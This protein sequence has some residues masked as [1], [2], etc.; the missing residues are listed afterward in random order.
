VSGKSSKNI[1]KIIL[2]IFL[3]LIAFD[4]TVV[5]LLFVPAVQT[6]AVSKVTQALSK[7]WESEISIQKVRIS[8]TLKIKVQ[9]VTIKDHHDNDMI[10]AATVKGRLRGLSIKPLELRFGKLFLDKGD[11]TLRTYAH[12]KDIN[13]SLW[14]IRISKKAKEQGTFLLTAQ[15]LTLKDT[16][17]VLINDN[18]RVVFD[19]RNHPDID[20]AY[21]EFR[22]INALVKDFKVDAKQI[23]TIS[24][25]F[26]DLALNQYSGF[27][28]LRCNGDFSICDTALNFQKCHI[29]TPSSNLDFDLGFSYRDWTTLGEFV[30]SVVIT[31]NVRPSTVCMQDVA[32]FAPAIKGMKETFSFTAE[33]F[34]GTVNDFKIDN[35]AAQWGMLTKVNGDLSIKNVTDF[36]HADISLQLAPSSVNVP[37]LA[38]F[39]L[40]DGNTIPVNSTVGRLGTAKISGSFIGNPTVFDAHFNLETA[41][42]RIYADLVTMVQGQKTK[43]EGRVSSPNLNLNS[44][45]K[46]S[47]TLGL[48]DFFIT[49]DGEMKGTEL[50]ANNFKTMTAS[51]SGD[52]YRIDLLGYP[53]KGT[54]VSG[55]YKNKLYNCSVSAADPHLACDIIAQLDLTQAEPALQAYIALDRCE[56]GKIA[57]HLPSI[58]SATAK[59]FDK[60]IYSLQKDPSATLAFD[61]FSIVLRGTSLDNING[62]A[63]C[64]NIRAVSADGDISNDRLRLTAINTENI[65]KFILSS[66]IASASLE[67]S[68][69]VTGIADSLCSIAKLFFPT[70]IHNSIASTPTNA[71]ANGYLHLHLTTDRTYKLTR[72]FM[73]GLYI[74]PNTDLDITL[75]S[76]LSSNRISLSLPYLGLNRQI[77]IHQLHLE[78]DANGSPNIKLSMQ[79]DSA[80]LKLN[81][82]SLAFNR[83]DFDANSTP[84][85]IHY[86]LE[87]NSPFIA[88]ASR[89]SNLSG[90]INIAN[91]QDIILRLTNSVLYLND[92]AWRFNNDNSIHFQKENLLFHNLRLANEGGSI[93][94][95]GAYSQS[96]QDK[97]NVTL[98]NVDLSIVN[99]FL[100]TLSFGGQLSADATITTRA[101]RTV[102]FGKT[103]AKDFVFN[104]ETLG[105]LFLIAGLDTAGRVRFSGGVFD[106]PQ[107][108]KGSIEFDQYNFQD[109]LDEKKIIARI[110]GTYGG[111][112]LEAHATFDTL[113]AGFVAPFLS[114]FS[115]QF[116]GS[117]SG[118]LA[119]YASPKS[120]YFDGTVHANDIR[121]GIAPLGTVYNIQ[122]Q[123]IHFSN[124]GIFFNQLRI[125]D[126]EG[127]VAH[128]NGSILHNFFENMKINLSINTNRVMA[129]NTPKTP[130]SVFYGKGFVAG[131]VFIIGDEKEI[132]FK[133]DQLRTLTGTEIVLQV[134]SANSITQSNIIH[135]KPREVKSDVNTQNIFNAPESSTSLKY[136]FGFDV[137]N[138]ADVQLYL[139]AIGGLMKARVDGHLQLTYSDNEDLNL[140]GNLAIH[141]G[142]F[143]IAL[144][145]LVNSRFTLVPGGTISFDGPLEEM[146][147]KVSAFKSS[148]TSLSSII[149][150]DLLSGNSTNV[151]AYIYLNGHLMQRIEPTFG[152]TLPSSSEEVRNSFYTAIDTSNKENITK[153]FAYFLIT[154]SFMPNN[155]FSN[156]GNSNN[157]PGLNLFSNIL[158]NLISSMID[159]KKG[160]FGLTYNQA[161]ETSSAEYGVNASANLLKNRIS[162]ETSIGY[163]DDANTSRW[164]NMYGD[165]TVEYR[166]N[167]AG[168]WRLK[169]YTNIGDRDEYQNRYASQ[170]NYTAGLAL[171]YKQDFNTVRRKNRNKKVKNNGKQ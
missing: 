63:G 116:S 66:N 141:S 142:D 26:N 7:Q 79:S 85:A 55:D 121:M 145:N 4:L 41:L 32:R 93:G 90:D 119:F 35:M 16:R 137:T 65:H 82:S 12:E 92:Q 76:D 147:T 133:G 24:C 6:F 37:N 64:D 138:D 38:N 59:G 124:K 157:K 10:T 18:E 67:T 81:E 140:N 5:G 43:F 58:D 136:D 87:W 34:K 80:T 62:Y 47:K 23:V 171:A 40:P 170:I 127:N 168:T 52:I 117:A 163:Y 153:Q 105:D 165:F 77:A 22:D 110:R 21:L 15:K 29:K 131:D 11:V 160:S 144:F 102:I 123:D 156:D 109:F 14:A 30:D 167:K 75:N 17:F 73:P 148:K 84:Q 13:I 49:A 8:P 111:K 2:W 48:C 162:L 74:A 108:S 72:I 100:P 158:N 9:G 86:D 39:T 164:S 134:S 161:T 149:S 51:L 45:T 103:L 143:K 159:S 27:E 146:T 120:T 19:T 61:N 106:N 139:E 91:D 42:G 31:A 69:P 135:F 3:G 112:Q 33:S 1:G 155:M 152:F 68:Y 97:L 96:E 113:R 44:L 115:D 89:T 28:M 71:T 101:K 99:P 169:A 107:L 150:Q 50:T 130:T 70:L 128:L 104:R 78:A 114:G 125:F 132:I 126:T 154:N 95:D 98:D 56:G 166:I 88:D 54:T 25:H 122:D 20:F 118:D 53:L 151:N 57:Q 46:S 83:L 129:L 36:L 60:V 94:V